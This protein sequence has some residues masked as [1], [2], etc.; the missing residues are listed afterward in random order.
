MNIYIISSDGKRYEFVHDSFTV[1]C[2][3]DL[4]TAVN[5]ITEVYTAFQRQYTSFL[6]KMFSAKYNLKCLVS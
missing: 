5:V 3:F 2:P 4:P 1:H 6:S